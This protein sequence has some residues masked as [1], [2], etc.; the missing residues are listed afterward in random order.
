MIAI[1]PDSGAEVVD[2]SFELDAKND[3]P[4]GIVW[5]DGVLYVGDSQDGKLYAYSAPR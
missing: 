1:E 2:R 4:D 3:V 5:A